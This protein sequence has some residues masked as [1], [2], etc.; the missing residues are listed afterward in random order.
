MRP[1]DT[2]PATENRTMS[3]VRPTDL[4]LQVL[5]I[6]WDRGPSSVRQVMGRLDDGKP[7]AYT[8]VLTILQV[9][10][11]K[12][13]VRHTREGLTYI[14][15]PAVAREQVTR[16]LVRTLLESAFGGDP[17]AVVQSLV[18]CGDVDAEQLKAIRRVINEAARKAKEGKAS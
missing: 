18:D 5:S 3:D 11:K 2:S 4:E 13:L 7:R 6:L 12:G 1:T 14:Y 16:P 8:T 15:Q 10:E 17:S 9:M